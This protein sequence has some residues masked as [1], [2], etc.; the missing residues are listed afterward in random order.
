MG[1]FDTSKSARN[2]INNPHVYFSREIYQSLPTRHPIHLALFTLATPVNM[3]EEDLIDFATQPRPDGLAGLR[4][5]TLWVD[6]PSSWFITAESRFQLHGIVREQTRY[7]YLVAALSKEAVSLVLDI[8][9]NP[10]G[11]HP[12]TALKEKAAGVTS[13]Q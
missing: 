2:S 4:L 13:A 12:Y 8:V 9:E 11:H 7:D 10:P 1:E 3:D 5:P 6:K